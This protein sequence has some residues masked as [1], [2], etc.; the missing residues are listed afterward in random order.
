VDKWELQEGGR[1]D[2]GVWQ[3]GRK[4]MRRIKKGYLFNNKSKKA[5]DL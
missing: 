4:G 2:A 5:K 3:E 1:K